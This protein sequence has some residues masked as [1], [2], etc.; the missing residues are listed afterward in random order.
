MYGFTQRA[1]ACLRRKTTGAGERVLLGLTT[2]TEVCGLCRFP[3]L[4]DNAPFPFPDLSVPP[5]LTVDS[6]LM[7]SE[8]CETFHHS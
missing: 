1:D 4:C 6:S 5:E 2:R 7:N 8:A 3:C